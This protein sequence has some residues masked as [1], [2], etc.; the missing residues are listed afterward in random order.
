M[1]QAK[2]SLTDKL[3]KI[4]GPF[5]K[6]VNGNIYVSAIRDAMLAYMPFTFI[7]SIFLIIL[8]IHIFE[9]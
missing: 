5:A 6:K 9:I 2:E 3:Q 8:C 7:S 4:V 1:N